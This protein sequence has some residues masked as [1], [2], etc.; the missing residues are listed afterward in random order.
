[1]NHPLIGISG[2]ITKDEKQHFL[3][4][5]YM[6]RLTENG[7]IP[8]LLSSDMDDDQIGQCARQ[9]DGLMLAGGNDIAPSLYGHEPIPQLGEVNPLRDQLE[10]KLIP[11]FLR[12]KKPIL[13]ICRGIQAL[14]VAMGGS[15]YQDLP[16]QYEAIS[17][18]ASPLCHSQPE[19]YEHPCH[20][21]SVTPGS[22]LGR[23]V[24]ETTLSVNS[25]HH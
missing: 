22:L 18:G 16:A 13:G 4:R 17:V 14:N 3:L 19:P 15:L 9:L 11:A 12:E 1:M 10:M 2:S 5:C 20:Q 7:A 21:V 6:Q 25:M 24:G 23:I 8:L